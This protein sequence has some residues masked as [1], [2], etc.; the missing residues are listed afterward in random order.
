MLLTELVRLALRALSA[1]KLRAFL[2]TLGISIGIAAVIALLAIGTGVQEYINQQFASA[3]T[4]LIGILP[5]RIQRGG[6]PGGFGQ[7]SVLTLSDYRA[8]VNGVPGSL[9]TPRTSPQWATSPSARKPHK[10]R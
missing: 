7:S 6:P 5:G 9:R 10:C 8:V 1:N 4:N 3:G 2:T